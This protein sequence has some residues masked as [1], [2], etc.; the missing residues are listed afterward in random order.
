VVIQ[1][2]YEDTSGAVIGTRLTTCNE[3]MGL[4]TYKSHLFTP[5]AD[6]RELSRTAMSKIRNSQ[7]KTVLKELHS[8]FGEKYKMINLN[9]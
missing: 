2:D 5:S 1:L 4:I 6:N 9:I 8:N 3:S 7:R